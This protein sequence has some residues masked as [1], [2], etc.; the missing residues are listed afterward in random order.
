MRHSWQFKG[1]RCDRVFF[2]GGGCSAILLLHLKNPRILRKSGA[3]RVARQGVPAHVCNYALKQINSVVTDTK[4]CSETIYIYM[5]PLRTSL[6]SSS[7]TTWYVEDMDTRLEQ[8]TAC[9]PAP[10]AGLHSSLEKRTLRKGG[11]GVPEQGNSLQNAHP[12]LEAISLCTCLQVLWWMPL[13]HRNRSDF[14]DLRMRCP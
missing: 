13:A 11:E 9:R 6:T 12:S 8:T 4:R 2:G 1:D 10:R 5:S 3:T 7:R 14:C